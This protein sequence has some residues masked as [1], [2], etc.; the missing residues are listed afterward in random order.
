[1][2]DPR[3]IPH[4]PAL[5]ALGQIFAE[6]G[7]APFVAQ[8]LR[9]LTGRQV[10]PA[11]VQVPYVRYRPGKSCVVLWSCEDATGA[12]LLASGRLFHNERAGKLLANSANRRLIAAATALLGGD[13]AP[14]RYF[15]EEKLL[16]QVFPLDLR[17]P[18]L[19]L[20]ADEAWLGGRL[21]IN[22]S[23]SQSRVVSAKP[24]SYKPWRRCVYR[25]DVEAAGERKS[26]Y[27]KLFRD[28]RGE[29]LL[30]SHRAVSASLSA[31][32]APWT[33][34]TAAGYLPEARML[35]F[36]A[37]DDVVKVRA[38][39]RPSLKDAA[40]KQKLLGYISTAAEGLVAFQR[41]PIDNLPSQTPQV[42]IDAFRDYCAGIA[43]V[44]PE[45][46]AAATRLLDQLESASRV[47][48][49]EPLVPTHGAFRHDQLLDASGRLIVLD[50]DTI[51]SSG[52]SADAGNFLGYLDLTAVRRP[53]LQP[54]IDECARTFA[55]KLR[56]VGL[57][58]PHWVAWYRAAAHVKK[59]L[60][61]FFSLEPNW[62]ETA[63]RMLAL[64]E[65]TL[66]DGSGA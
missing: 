1:V 25:Y 28:D 65:A 66:R 20:A 43:T 26:Y 31:S 30:D 19:V 53:R 44:A 56:D 63:Q 45:F 51:C 2:S 22:G 17:L 32:H 61:S 33:I 54:I 15:P 38:L 57:A 48:P 29:E 13:N 60:R 35:L 8:A 36:D 50:L 24:V 55:G 42:L 14:Y 62:P 52:E 23:K 49:A 27:A 34:P 39:L 10:E 12:P 21:A 18:K 11:A 41:S 37:I 46:A 64:A 9:Q 16:A 58:S 5:P 4:D 3:R 40:T 7:A 47:F 6:Q 59:G